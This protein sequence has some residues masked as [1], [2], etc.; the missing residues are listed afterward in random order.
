VNVILET[1]EFVSENT[2]NSENEEFISKI[3]RINMSNCN[4]INLNISN[5]VIIL[6]L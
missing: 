2:E 4:N 3:I 1:P 6:Q 5:C